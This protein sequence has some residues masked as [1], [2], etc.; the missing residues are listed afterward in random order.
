MVFEG[1]EVIVSAWWVSGFPGLALA[2]TVVSWNLVGD[3]L[4][5]CLDVRMG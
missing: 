2:L 5:D 3:G 4:R 1:R